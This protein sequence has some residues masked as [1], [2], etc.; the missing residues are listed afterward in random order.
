MYLWRRVGRRKQ[1]CG[2]G[3]EDSLKG[4]SRAH[5]RVKAEFGLL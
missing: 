1:E 3:G 4:T 5:S 2:G